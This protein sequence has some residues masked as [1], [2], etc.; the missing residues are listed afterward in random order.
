MGRGHTGPRVV[1]TGVGV[2]FGLMTMEFNRLR[3]YDQRMNNSNR[4]STRHFHLHTH[5]RTHIDH[6]AI[7][8][9]MYVRHVADALRMDS[10]VQEL[11][12]D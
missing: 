3:M 8:F 4:I 5:S 2:E 12:L 10:I 6:T 1:F 7:M 11:H 9:P